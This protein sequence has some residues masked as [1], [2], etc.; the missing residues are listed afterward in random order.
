[1]QQKRK[2]I[3]ASRSPA[4]FKL[5]KDLGLNIGRAFADIDESYFKGESINHHTLRLAAMKAEK[6][7][8]KN[9]KDIVIGVDT[10]IVF[11]NK[12]FGKPINKK[13][14]EKTLRTLSGKWHEVHSGT[15]II[16]AKSGKTI[17]KLVISRVRFAKLSK[18]MIDWYI[19]TGEPLK[20]AGAYSIQNKGSCLIE[21]VDGCLTNVIGISI[22]WILSMLKKLNAL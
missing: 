14:A 19:R 10:V 4:R 1:M 13:D 15:V 12:I 11:K 3:L 5:L 21:A 16:D 17:K 22:P 9:K 2:I 18:E 7:A 20:A 8:A 6:I